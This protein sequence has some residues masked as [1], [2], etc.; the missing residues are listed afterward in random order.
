MVSLGIR[1]EMDATSN[2]GR[3]THLMPVSWEEAWDN[4]VE[5]EK[6]K[7]EPVIIKWPVVA[8]KTGKIERY[9]SIPFTEKKQYV[10]NS[11]YDDFSTNKLNLHWN[12]RRVPR[13]NTYELD[14]KK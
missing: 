1:N 7:W 6:G 14:A 13:K 2:M 4:W 12:F 3:E 8:P 11:F 5:V 10:D 9:N